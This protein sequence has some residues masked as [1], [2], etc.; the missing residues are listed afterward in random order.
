MRAGMG[1]LAL[2]VAM[3]LT[4]CTDGGGDRA[5]MTGEGRAC[6]AVPIDTVYATLGVQFD[7]ATGANVDQTFTCLLGIS[8]QALPELSVAISETSAS[9]LVFRT[10]LTPSGAT[11][12]ESL[13]RAAYQ[14]S[15]PPGTAADGTATGPAYEIG[16]L[17]TAP[18]VTTLRYTWPA[19]AT[20]ADVAALAPQLLTLASHVEAALVGPA[21]L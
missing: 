9:A 21:P 1:A 15:L 20:D 16:W 4:G 3:L 8:E 10:R 11:A 6:Q 12:M 19:D 5:P 2:A 17:S 18:R 14:L 7:F 13:G